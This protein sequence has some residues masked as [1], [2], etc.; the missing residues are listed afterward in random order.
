MEMLWPG[1]MNPNNVP[2]D[3]FY[4]VEHALRILS[5]Q[6]NLLPEEMPPQW[7]WHLDWEIEAWFD[8]IK[9]KREQE[10]GGPAADDPNAEYVENEY[11][12][13]MMSRIKGK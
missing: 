6:E 13:E 1:G 2:S 3:L 4:A 7:M 8:K 9:A 11:Y 12:H 10:R 5:W